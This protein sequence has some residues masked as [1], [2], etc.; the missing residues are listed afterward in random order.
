MRYNLPPDKIDQ[1][2]V[3]EGKVHPGGE[4]RQ[5]LAYQYSGPIFQYL[6]Q[7]EQELTATETIKAINANNIRESSLVIN[8][9]HDFMV[10]KYVIFPIQI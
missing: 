5:D 3:K 10:I 6:L 1:A 7:L 2:P 8:T 9:L 4:F